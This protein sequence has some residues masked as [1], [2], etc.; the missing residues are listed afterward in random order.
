VSDTNGTQSDWYKWT[1]ACLAALLI[2]LIPFFV[3]QARYV[4]KSDVDQAT[5]TVATS[6]R[7]SINALTAEV[8]A[9]SARSSQNEADIAQINAQIVDLT[10]RIDQLRILLQLQYPNPIGRIK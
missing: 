1:A 5:G 2:G 6:L 10:D 7:E 3:A 8:D 4:K 9:I